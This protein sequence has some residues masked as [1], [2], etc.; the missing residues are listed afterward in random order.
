MDNT[1]NNFSQSTLQSSEPSAYFSSSSDD[2]GFF[3][4]I[5]ATTWIL[6]ILILAFLGF[7]IFTYLAK[8][9][10]TITDIF[11]PIM[12]K[13]FGTT[14]AVTGQAIDVSAEGAKAVVGGTAGALESG[15][16]TVQNITPNMASSNIK[17]QPMN[18]QPSDTSQQS[19]LNRALNTAQ[20]QQPPQED[21]QATE[22]PS[23]VHSAGKAGWC[24]V[25]NDRGFRTCAQVGVNDTCMSGDIFPSQEICM[26]PNLRT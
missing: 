2:K 26:N 18:Q 9:T 24:Y 13:L 11:A 14:V 12:D 20:S 4:N 25:G 16:T 22:A 1:T 6:I 23:S 19:T 5:N 8:G 7:N 15:L 3:G 17:G 10:Q 21:Y